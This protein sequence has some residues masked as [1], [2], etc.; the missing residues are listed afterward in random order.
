MHSMVSLTTLQVAKDTYDVKLDQCEL[1]SA[2][3]LARISDY[4]TSILLLPLCTVL[5]WQPHDL[6]HIR[7]QYSWYACCQDR[8]SYRD[9]L[10]TVHT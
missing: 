6:D 3:I 2:A 10:G 5:Q 1:P 4:T 7:I 8:N 9:G